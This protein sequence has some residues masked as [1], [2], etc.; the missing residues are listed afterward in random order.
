MVFLDSTKGC[1]KRRTPKLPDRHGP[2]FKG[3]VKKIAGKLTSRPDLEAEGKTE[4]LGSGLHASSKRS[5]TTKRR[6][7]L[8]PDPHRRG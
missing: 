1:M 7:R 3:V 2:E 8:N 4:M 6:A 5:Q